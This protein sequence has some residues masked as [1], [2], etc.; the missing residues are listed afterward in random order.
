MPNILTIMFIMEVMNMPDYKRMYLEMFRETEK[1]IE[2]L[3]AAQRQCEEM[4]INAPEAKIQM[5]PVGD[6]VKNE[7]NDDRPGL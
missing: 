7:G 5:L 4:Y 3:I 6:E 1:A 2:I